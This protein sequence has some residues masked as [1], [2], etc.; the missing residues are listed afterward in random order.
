M[1]NKNVGRYPKN[2]P[3]PFF[4]ENNNCITCHSPEHE[5]PD[6]MT[7]DEGDYGHCYF[8]R[9]P[10]TFEEKRQ[11]VRACIVSC[12]GSVRYEGN[13]PEILCLFDEAAAE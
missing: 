8:K 10:I 13:D 7:H 3:G 4:V 2:A 12:C 11:A 9:Q 5:A 1:K 6:L